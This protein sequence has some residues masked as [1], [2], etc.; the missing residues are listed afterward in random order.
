MFFESSFESD[1][2]RRFRFD[3]F[4]NFAQIFQLS[5][6]SGNRRAA[7]RADEND[8]RTAF[9]FNRR[10]ARRAIGWQERSRDTSGDFGFWILDFGF[11]ISALDFPEH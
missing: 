6:S 3:D 1:F 4:R 9:E 5:V 8:G 7:K 2:Q 10:G 11:K